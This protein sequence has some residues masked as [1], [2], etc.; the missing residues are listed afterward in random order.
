MLQAGEAAQQCAPWE[1][2]GHALL[3]CQLSLWKLDTPAGTQEKVGLGFAFG[4][5][6]YG[7]LAMGKLKRPVLDKI[8]LMGSENGYMDQWAM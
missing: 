5:D 3:S 1:S 4:F 8:V 7:C 6:V 2:F